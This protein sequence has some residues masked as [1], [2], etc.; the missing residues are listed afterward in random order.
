VEPTPEIVT[1]PDS[2]IGDLVRHGKLVV[3][4]KGAAAPDIRSKLSRKVATSTIRTVTAR[5]SLRRP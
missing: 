4:L 3:D 2:A 1:A 5:H